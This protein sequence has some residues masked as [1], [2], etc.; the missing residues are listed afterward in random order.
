MSY[1]LD[2]LETLA[3]FLKNQPTLNI[4]DVPLKEETRR[5]EKL[6]LYQLMTLTNETQLRTYLQINLNKLVE[7][8]DDLYLPG[9]EN[10]SAAT[11]LDLFNN[12][13]KASGYIIPQDLEIPLLLRNRLSIN[14]QTSWSYI[15]FKLDEDIDPVLIE[16]VSFAFGNFANS[17]IRPPWSAVK[18]MNLLA[19]TLLDLPDRVDTTIIIYFL[20]KLGY[21]YSRFTVYC[22]R[23]IEHKLLNLSES[24]KIE[25][26]IN[27][28]REFRQLELLSTENYD[29]RKINMVEELC[30]WL[31]EEQVK[32]MAHRDVPANKM[33]LVSNLKVLQLAYWK[34]LQYDHGVYD[35]INLDVL[36]EKVAHNFSTKN[37]EEISAPSIKSKFYPKDRLV[38]QPI[39]G[40]LIRML[41]D[42]R[43]FLK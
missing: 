24:S 7:I 18:Y 30:K 38:V 23:W 11:V 42:V 29:T 39:E 36:S 22:Y 43:L 34:K 26:I 4:L 31:E 20:I 35:E 28:K 19:E 33:K 16:I 27:L 32:L 5:I 15:R 21:N 2:L 10:V 8:C 14:F 6:I 25:V 17:V 3:T 40:L 37:Q 9:Q 12:V 41:E 13:R 1:D